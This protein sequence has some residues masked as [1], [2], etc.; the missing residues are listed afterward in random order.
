MEVSYLEDEG[1]KWIIL[2]RYSDFVELHENLQEFF[3]KKKQ[4]NKNIKVPDVPP[5]INK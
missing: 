2:K 5:Q 4:V 1:A 3:E